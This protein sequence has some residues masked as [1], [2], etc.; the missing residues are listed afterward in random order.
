MGKRLAGLV[1]RDDGLVS[2]AD[3]IRAA[4]LVADGEGDQVAALGSRVGKRKPQ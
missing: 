1:L 4:R 3:S 2:V